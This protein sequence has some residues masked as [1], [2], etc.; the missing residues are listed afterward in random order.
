MAGSVLAGGV[1]DGT[2]VDGDVG[3]GRR[4]AVDEGL[5]MTSVGI[6]SSTTS[7]ELTC[8]LGLTESRRSTIS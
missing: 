3:E 7:G 4:S 6:G 8:S 2:K 1:D 5:G